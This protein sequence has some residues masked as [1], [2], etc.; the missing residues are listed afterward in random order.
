[1][2]LLRDLWNDPDP[3]KWVIFGGA[4][5]ALL[6]GGALAFQVSRLNG[7]Q[8]E[9]DKAL[10]K[11]RG[12]TAQAPRGSLQEI[13]DKAYEVKGYVDQ[14]KEDKLIDNL[15]NPNQYIQQQGAFGSLGDLTIQ[16]TAGGGGTNYKDITFNVI[17]PRDKYASREQIKAFLYNIQNQ[18]ALM[19]VTYIHLFPFGGNHRPGMTLGE[20]EKDEKWSFDARFT[21]RQ[22]KT[23]TPG[24]RQ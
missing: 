12:A 21:I 11:P 23:E 20:D 5:A 19:T 3:I 15:D 7:L 22:R 6:A 2:G 24:G 14:V 9:L 13:A 8:A 10:A 4:A 1:M 17:P 16:P 18:S